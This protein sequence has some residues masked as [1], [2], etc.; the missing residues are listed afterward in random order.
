MDALN[1]RDKWGKTA[2]VDATEKSS[3]N[4]IQLLSA[5]LVVTCSGKMKLYRD[6]ICWPFFQLQAPTPC[7]HRPSALAV[8][9]DREQRPSTEDVF[10]PGDKRP[11]A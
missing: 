2:L 1:S 9:R 6:S 7:C 5:P 10:Y 4:I 3:F 11:R 8:S